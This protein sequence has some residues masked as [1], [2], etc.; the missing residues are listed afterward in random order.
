MRFT[1][2]RSTLMFRPPQSPL[3]DVMTI[4]DRLDRVA[5]DEELV[6]VLGA[7]V[8]Q[9]AEHCAHA[10]PVGDAR[11][12]RAGP[13]ASWRRRPSPWPGDLLR[14]LHAVDLVRIS[15]PLAMGA[16]PPWGWR[17]GRSRN[18]PG[19]AREVKAGSPPREVPPPGPH[20]DRAPRRTPPATPGILASVPGAS[21][22]RPGTVSAIARG[23][24]GSQALRNP[25]R[26]AGC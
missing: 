14:A 20:A 4:S 22:A 6:P 23:H 21:I 1:T 10:F 7:R 12:M 15:R 2:V 25:Q 3:S 8:A 19:L 17:G 11:C 9:V 26:F 24:R 18:Y 16:V 5:L 13:C